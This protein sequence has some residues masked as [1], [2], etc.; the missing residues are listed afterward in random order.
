MARVDR[1]EA[2]QCFI[3]LQHVFHSLVIEQ[4]EGLIEG[5][6]KQML[7]QF[8]AI[9]ATFGYSFVMTYVILKVL[10]MLFGLRVSDEE[11]QIGVDAAQ[12]G[13][14]GYVFEESGGPGYVGIPQPTTS[15]EA[16][17]AA[18][19]SAGGAG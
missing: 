17:A 1:L 8:A 9:G 10:D 11:E 16:D 3:Q 7:Y 18:S 15:S 12:H 19:A 6:S 4:V 2:L 14:R 5:E 13:E